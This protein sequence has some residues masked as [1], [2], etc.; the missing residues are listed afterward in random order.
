MSLL[1][2]KRLPSHDVQLLSISI[3]CTQA[4]VHEDGICHCILHV[5]VQ[6]LEKYVIHVQSVGILNLTL[7]D[8]SKL[9][10]QLDVVSSI[11]AHDVA[12]CIV[13]PVIVPDVI[14]S[15]SI[16]VIYQLAFTVFAH[17]EGST[18]VKLS[19]V[20]V[21]VPVNILFEVILFA[22]ISFAV[23]VPAAILSAVINTLAPLPQN[24]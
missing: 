16:D 5:L 19:F 17:V 24:T 22:A 11:L 4:N 12:V 23:I 15:A 13:L 20:A 7:P 2:T 3:K 9:L 10:N 1:S 6:L 8:A 14:L 18:G 21:I